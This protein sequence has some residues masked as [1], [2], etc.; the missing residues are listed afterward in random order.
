MT[1]LLSYAAEAYNLLPPQHCG[2]RPGRTGEDAM[3]ILMERIHHGW[4]ERE[5]YTV[6]LM[7]IA[8]AFNNVHH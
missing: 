4:K 6:L 5:V 3:L 7:D 8:G 2:R 1:E